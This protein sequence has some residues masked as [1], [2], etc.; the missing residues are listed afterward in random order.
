VGMMKINKIA[1]LFKKKNKQVPFQIEEQHIEKIK[2]IVP[3]AEIIYANEEDELLAKTRDA[4]ILLTWGMY[5]PIQFCK[6]AKNLKWIHTLSA[7]VDGMMVPEISN[8]DVRISNTKG[9]HGIPIAN[10]TLAYILS[11]VCQFPL[12]YRQ[13]QNKTWNKL[14]NPE[15]IFGKTVGIVGL[16]SIGEEIARQCKLLG[17]RVVATKRTPIEC[18]WVDY[19]YTNEELGA[20]LKVSDFVVVAV[21]LTPG[22]NKLIGEKELKLMKKSAYFINI[23]R[24]GVVDE[25]ALIHVLQKGLIAGAGLDVFEEEPLPSNHPLWDMANVIIT[26]HLAADSPLYMERAIDVFGQNL[27]RFINN[28]ELLFEINKIHQY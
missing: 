22:T 16:G 24:G 18:E 28:E 5:K 1:I 3:H 15:E 13:Q 2:S 11:F 17:M 21:P 7:G 10:H 20:L 27:L 19:L 9:I 25:A 26:P 23:A 8:L 12:L 14:V 6:S 4:D